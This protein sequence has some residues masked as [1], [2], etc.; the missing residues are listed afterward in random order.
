MGAGKFLPE[1][2]SPFMKTLLL[3]AVAMIVAFLV[4]FFWRHVIVRLTYRTRTE[5]DKSVAENLTFPLTYIVFVIGLRYALAV[6][7]GKLG[8]E[9]KGSIFYRTYDGVLYSATVLLIAFGI[10]RFLAGFTRWYLRH[11]AERTASRLDDEF[12]PLFER[13]SKLLLLFVGATI[14]LKHFNQDISA[15]VASVG[16]GSLAIAFAAQETLANMI[17]GFTIMLDR[18]FRIGDRIEL[19]SGVIGD[20][21]EI[22]L[23]STKILTFDNTLLVVPNAEISRSTIVNHSY[24]DPKVKLRL[25]IGVAYGS[26]MKRV[27]EVIMDTLTSHPDILDEPEPMVF[28]EEFGDSSLNLLYVFW[29][30]DYKERFRIIDEVNMAINERF[31]QEGIEI[32]FQQIDIHIRDKGVEE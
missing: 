15:L 31:Q 8:E 14:I 17:A 12:I 32:P 30:L 19:S 3:S 21:Y 13:L 28:F 2:A 20:V 27:K 11:V 5:L 4:Y 25:R 26:D 10:Y 22:G 29:I 16:I 9:I 23:R 7:V 18:P 1:D 24:P 6:G